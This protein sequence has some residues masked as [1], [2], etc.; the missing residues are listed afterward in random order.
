MSK[1][2]KQIKSIV[3][4]NK[5]QLLQTQQAM[6]RRNIPYKTSLLD[7]ADIISSKYGVA[8]VETLSPNG[9]VHAAPITRPSLQRPN[10]HRFNHTFYNASAFNTKELA[11]D[12][13][14]DVSILVEPKIVPTHVRN[15]TRYQSYLKDLRESWTAPKK[16][17]SQRWFLR[18][19]NHM[20]TW[21]PVGRT[22]SNN[23][24][25]QVESA[26]KQV[27]TLH[28]GLETAFQ[29]GEIPSSVPRDSELSPRDSM[30]IEGSERDLQR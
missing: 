24:T 20:P 3:Q 23:Y 2:R 22:L 26:G 11:E 7:N 1:Y 9:S 17:Q 19:S 18:A 6:R 21:L 8:S 15:K 5:R 4:E 12:V 16:A 10:R 28:S 29:T 25:R 14:T 30:T 13:G 27:S